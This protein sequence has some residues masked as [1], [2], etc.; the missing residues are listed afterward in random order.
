[1][2]LEFDQENWAYSVLSVLQTFDK[3][4]AVEING[5]IELLVKLM[6]FDEVCLEGL[7]D[8]VT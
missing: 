5:Y 2:S 8:L 6:K 4:S 7:R 3:L 1:M